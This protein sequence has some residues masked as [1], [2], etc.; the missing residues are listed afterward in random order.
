M[1]VTVPKSCIDFTLPYSVKQTL[2]ALGVRE[3][4]PYTQGQTALI[5]RGRLLDK[6][7][8]IKTLRKDKSINRD[9][10]LIIEG[11]TLK[12]LNRKSVGPQLIEYDKDFVVMEYISGCT[13]FEYIE[14]HASKKTKEVLQNIIY[15]YHI[16]DQEELDKRESHKIPKHIIIGNAVVLIDFEKTRVSSKPKNV[17]GFIGALYAERFQKVLQAHLV[18]LASIEVTTVYCKSYI[19]N[20][21]DNT[22]DKL[23]GAMFI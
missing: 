21:C 17:S 19:I 8:I 22:L 2:C 10:P 1:I 16:I 4:S 15:Q 20:P 12:K 9:D 6:L 11:E 7:V 5:H 18:D 23:I 3:Y 13:L 14:S